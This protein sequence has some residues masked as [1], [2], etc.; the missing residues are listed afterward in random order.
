[1]IEFGRMLDINEDRRRDPNIVGSVMALSGCEMI[2]SELRRL[3]WRSGARKPA[4]DD[5]APIGLH[6]AVTSSCEPLNIGLVRKLG[7]AIALTDPKEPPLD[8]NDPVLVGESLLM[9]ALDMFEEEI[10]RRRVELD[11]EDVR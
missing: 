2:M 8:E 11:A 10:K 6:P 5:A 9:L 1:V 7:R 4:A 3:G